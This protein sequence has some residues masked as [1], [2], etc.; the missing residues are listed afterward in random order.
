VVALSGNGRD[1]IRSF[2]DR[3][4]ALASFYSPSLS[5]EIVGS[6]AAGDSLQRSFLELPRPTA[7]VEAVEFGTAVGNPIQILHPDFSIV[8]DACRYLGQN[9]FANH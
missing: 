6:A 9:G 7:G 8:I 4:Q 2:G 1:R 5:V 3:R